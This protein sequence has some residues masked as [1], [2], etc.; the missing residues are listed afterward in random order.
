VRLLKA[1]GNPILLE[2]RGLHGRINKKRIYFIWEYRKI[3]NL[4]YDPE[5]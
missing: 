3:I 5:I 4:V 1:E 2:V